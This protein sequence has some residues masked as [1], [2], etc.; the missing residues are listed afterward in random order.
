MEAVQMFKASDGTPFDSKEGCAAYEV[1]L[2]W[3]IEFDKF[4]DA[5]KAAG[6]G[7]NAISQFIRGAKLFDEFSRTGSVPSPKSRK[8]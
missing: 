1:A 3:K 8:K 5:L 4:R 6:H 2:A 7:K